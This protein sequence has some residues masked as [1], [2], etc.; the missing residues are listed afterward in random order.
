[1]SGDLSRPRVSVNGSSVLKK[2]TWLF[3][4]TLLALILRPELAQADV[5]SWM[6]VGAGVGRLTLPSG[7]NDT[8]TNRATLALDTGFGTSPLSPVVVGFAF[9]ALGYLEEGVDVGFALRGTS[10]GYSRGMWG[11]ALDVG[12]MQRFWGQSAT[13]PTASL[14]LG[15]PWGVTL[16]ATAGSDFDA[17]HTLGFTLGFDWARLTAHRASGESQWRN[18]RLPVEVR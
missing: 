8:T 1:M 15:L 11:V 5:A 13:L 7:S 2:S 6:Y 14:S 10:S 3:P 16:A 9:K 17:T 12:V 4:G 18:Y